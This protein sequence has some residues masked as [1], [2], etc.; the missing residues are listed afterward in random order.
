M[1]KKVWSS[2]LLTGIALTI[3]IA[4]VYAQSASGG[5]AAFDFLKISPISRAVG[6][7]GAYTAIGDDIGSIYYNPAGL[8]GLL[9]SEMNITYLSIYQS[10]NY[11]FL[12]FGYPLGESMPDIGGTVAISAALLQPGSLP[13][14]NDSGVTVNGTATFASGDQVFSLAYARDLGHFLQAG[15]CVN[16]I[17]QQIDTV[18]TSLFDA[19]AGVVIL[20]PFDGMRIGVSLKNMGAE[21]AGFDLPFTLNTGISYRHYELFSEQ[22]DGA[23]TAEVGFPLEP[24]EDPVGVKVGGEYNYKWMGNRATLRI[25]YEFL[26]TALDGAGLSLG[27]GY[28]LDFGG[29]VLF[30]DYAYSPEDI[31]GSDNRISLTT[32]F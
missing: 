28:G 15:F 25:G 14:T 18:S 7:G 2:F 3:G 32:K 23:L 21:A 10:I 31:F 1:Q 26:D 12:A 11:E 6:L 17:E 9:T 13:R 20:P 8:A 19:T 16:Y 22:D 4:P 29:A 24:I 27:A 30:L 5:Q